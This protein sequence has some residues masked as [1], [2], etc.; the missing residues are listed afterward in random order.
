MKEHY[1][2]FGKGLFK[3]FKVFHHSVLTVIYLMIA[4]GPA[5]YSGIPRTTSKRNGQIPS[6]AQQTNKDKIR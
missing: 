2:S 6:D 1:G 5:V 4:V 3:F